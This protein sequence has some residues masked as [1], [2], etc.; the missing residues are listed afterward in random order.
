M[1]QIN[2]TNFEA[3]PA[4]T[5]SAR[6][7]E[8][9]VHAVIET[10]RDTRHKYAFE[11]KLGLFKLK[12]TL[13]EGLQ[14]PYD[15]GFVPR[16]IADDGDPLDILVLNQIPTFTGCLLETRILGIVRLKKNGVENDRVLAAPLVQAGLSQPS[17]AFD[18]VDDLPKGTVDDIC[19]FLVEYSEEEGNRIEF[20]DVRSRKKAMAAI[21]SAKK[22]YEKQSK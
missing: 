18:D 21:E 5:G 20:K 17:D 13:P 14:W 22:A 15:Y 3:I 10:P 4:F 7:G 6:N 11:P 1:K 12:L 9:R 19:R 8:R 16:T 2:P